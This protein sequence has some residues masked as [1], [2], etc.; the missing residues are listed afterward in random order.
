MTASCPYAALDGAVTGVE[1]YW[2]HVAADSEVAAGNPVEE[3]NV[4]AV[5]Y[6][7]NPTCTPDVHAVAEYTHAEPV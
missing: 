3:M 2:V 5:L 4:L 7:L 6:Q 1:A